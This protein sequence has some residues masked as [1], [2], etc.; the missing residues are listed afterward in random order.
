[1]IGDLQ[2]AVPS[3]IAAE[4][5]I[6]NGALGNTKV[7]MYQVDYKPLHSLSDVFYDGF[8]HKDC[9]YIRFLVSES[10]SDI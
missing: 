1:M 9:K 6:S 4:Q 5:F 8:S 10:V 7:Y 2:M 3:D